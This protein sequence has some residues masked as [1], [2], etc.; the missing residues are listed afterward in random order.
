MVMFHCQI[1]RRFLPLN[2]KIDSEGTVSG[3][4]CCILLLDAARQSPS[5]THWKDV[6]IHTQL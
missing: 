4:F 5:Y 6:R 2:I 3:L 1:K